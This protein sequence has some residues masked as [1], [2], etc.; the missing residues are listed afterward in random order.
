MESQLLQ[1]LPFLHDRNPQVRQLALENLLGHTATD[2]SYRSI[3]FADRKGGGGL[4]SQKDIEL[5]RDLKLL[6]RDHLAIAHDAFRALINLSDSP[7]WAN[8]LSETSFLVFLVSYILHPPSVLADLAAMLLSNITA[9]QSTCAKLLTLKIPV[10]LDE[11]LKICFYPTQSRS[12]TSPPPSLPPNKEV[13]EVLALP[14]LLDAFVTS[15]KIRAPGGDQAAIRKGELN[16]LS[17]VFANMSVTPS[18][19]LFFL[20]P[21]STDALTLNTHSANAEYPLSRLV[22]FTEHPD[23]IRRGG[24]VTVIKN[25]AFHAPAHRALLSS[26]DEEVAIPPSELY[27]PGINLLPAIL[28][29]LA[30]PEEFDIEDQEK[31]PP[32]LQ[33]L[34]STKTREPD[35]VLRLTHIEALLL[36]CTTRWGREFLRENGAYEIVRTMHETEQIDKIS[37]HIERLVNLLMR[38]EGNDTEDNTVEENVSEDERIEEV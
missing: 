18:G 36:L 5:V 25:C 2:S 24:I 35:S 14:L 38:D 31:L 22:P 15:A 34:P 17:S 7:E 9:Q 37:E 28:L 6:C 12:G 21:R 29:P 20:T 27:A 19:R 26:E 10:I 1:L 4:Q 32:V 3:F 13:M 23:T 33:F 11:S 30:G 16:F 8:P